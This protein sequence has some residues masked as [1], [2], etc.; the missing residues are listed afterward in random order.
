MSILSIIP[1]ELLLISDHTIVIIPSKSQSIIQ[2]GQSRE[3]FE[4]LERVFR[5]S[6]VAFAHS[7]SGLRTFRT[8]DGNV[9]GAKTPHKGRENRKQD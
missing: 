5:V 3:N 7:L 6:C 2:F 9:S 1:H 4:I 8:R